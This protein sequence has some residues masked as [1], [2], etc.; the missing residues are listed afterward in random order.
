M[1]IVSEELLK[2]WRYLNENKVRYIMVGGAV[3]AARIG[4]ARNIGAFDIP[5]AQYLSGMENLRGFRRNRFAGRSMMFGNGEIRI[6]LGEFSTYFF[7]GSWGM[8]VF[9]DVGKV[10]MDDEESHRWHNGFGGGLWVAP[11]RRWVLTASV[12]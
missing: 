12:A 5:Q 4:M 6:R 3:Y 1:N 8:L 10:R 11:I 7:P 2:F 9:D